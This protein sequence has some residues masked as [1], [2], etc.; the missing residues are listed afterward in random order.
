[1]KSPERFSAIFC[2]FSAGFVAIQSR[3]LARFHAVEQ[4]E[5]LLHRPARQVPVGEQL[6]AVGVDAASGDLLDRR[7]LPERR[8]QVA[9]DH[10][11]VV[12]ERGLRDLL[13]MLAVAQPLR[14]HVLERDAAALLRADRERPAPRVGEHRVELLLSGLVG[15]VPAR[16]AATLAGPLA[17]EQRLHLTAVDEAILE[18]EDRAA[19][20]LNGL[21]V[22]GDARCGHQ[23]SPPSSSR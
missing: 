1:M 7:G 8:E 4:H 6:L 21:D 2:A 16:Y 3:C 20:A 5:H 19:L 14:A 15:E 18:V 12:R 9:V 23:T 17:T 22:P 11:A 10:V 13:V